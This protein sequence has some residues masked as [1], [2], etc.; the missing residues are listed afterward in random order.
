MGKSK[1]DDRIDSSKVNLELQFVTDNVDKL[2]AD[3]DYYTTK[4]YNQ[5]AAINPK[6]SLME[7]KLTDQIVRMQ[8]YP[9]LNDTSLYTSKDNIITLSSRNAYLS[10]NLFGYNLTEGDIGQL[11]L[12]DETRREL[13]IHSFYMDVSGLSGFS[14]YEYRFI[15]LIYYI[16]FSIRSYNITDTSLRFVNYFLISRFQTFYST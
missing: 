12:D 13:D 16:L 6:Y 2:Y 8:N 9:E 4:Q 10:S 14:R 1:E 15:P 3:N 11:T 7:P 5:W